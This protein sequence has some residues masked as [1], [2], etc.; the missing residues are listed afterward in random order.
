MK[1][2]L[3]AVLPAVGLLAAGGVQ[4]APDAEIRAA[5]G[6]WLPGVRIEAVRPSPVK[7]LYEV[8][9]DANV[10]Y[11]TA[12]GRYVFSG[13]LF[14][15]RAGRDLAERTRAAQRLKMIGEVPGDGMIIYPAKRKRHTLTVFT[16]VD[17]PYCRRFH[18]EVPEL[19]RRGV[20]VRYLLFPRGGLET[21]T[22]AKS[23]SVWC[24][25]D[26]KKALDAATRGET[27]PTRNCDNPVSA[28]YRLGRR[29]GVRGTPTL[30]TERG[31][32]L[33]GYIPLEQLVKMLAA[34]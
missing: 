34:R 6:R 22:Y 9:F 25:P 21:P 7:G 30:I 18:Q 3:R 8:T 31:D 33:T 19:V 5:L 27:L 24:A 1:G 11:A 20:E 15:T 14:D 23:I 32:K 17:C 26:R 12:D 10:F 28:H 16:D 2:W 13:A 4:A 29:I